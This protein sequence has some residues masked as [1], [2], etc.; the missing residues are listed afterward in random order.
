M[1]T[2]RLLASAA[3][4]IVAVFAAAAAAVIAVGSWDPIKDINDPHIQEL[5]GWAVAEHVRQAPSDAGL[6]FR[7]VTSGEMQEPD[8]TSYRLVLV[9]SRATGRR[10]DGIY[11]AQVLEHSDS[12]KLVSFVPAN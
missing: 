11:A 10:R 5:G 7:K 1:T 9:A 6:T 8:G 2:S 12:R 4:L 3:I